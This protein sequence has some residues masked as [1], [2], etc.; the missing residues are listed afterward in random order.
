MQL[1]TFKIFS[2]HETKISIYLRSLNEYRINFLINNMKLKLLYLL[3]LVQVVSYGQQQWRPLGPN[4]FNQ[5]SNDNT[6]SFSVALDGNDIP[7]MAFTSIASGVFKVSVRKF[8]NGYWEYVGAPRFSDNVFLQKVSLAIDNNNVPYVAYRTF[9]GQSRIQKF[10][11]GVWTNISFSE[12]FALP[13]LVFDT[14]NNLNILAIFGASEHAGLRKF[15]G[16]TWTSV[17]PTSISN[18]FTDNLSVDFDSNNIPYVAYSNFASNQTLT[19]KKLNNGAWQNVGD[20]VL[21]TND[22]EDITIRLNDDNVPYVVY[23]NVNF[24]NPV[25]ILK[26]FN[27]TQW[28]AVGP[29]N[30][31]IASNVRNVSFEIDQNDDLVVATSSESTGNTTV[32]KFDGTDWNMFGQ[33]WLHGYRNALVLNSINEPMVSFMDNLAGMKRFDGTQ[34]IILGDESLSGNSKSELFSMTI[35]GDD[36]PYF[37]YHTKD[38]TDIV[39]KKWN[40]VL[41]ENLSDETLTATQSVP[42]TMTTDANNIPYVLYRNWNTEKLSVKKLIANNWVSVGEETFTTVQDGTADAQ[43]VIDNS[44]VLYVAIKSVYNSVTKLKFYK[45]TGANWVLMNFQQLI[46]NSSDLGFTI[47][48][49]NRPVVVYTDANIAGKLQVRK[50]DSTG[51]Q[52]DL[53]GDGIQLTANPAYSY[54]AVDSQNVPYISYAGFASSMQVG[55]YRFFAG[56]WESVGTNLPSQ[57]IELPR[58]LIDKTD[59]PHI[60]YHDRDADNSGKMT[61]RKLEGS[62]WNVVGTAKLSASMASQIAMP[63]LGFTSNNVPVM[64]YS[65]L[66]YFAKFFGEENAL[67]VAQN[68]LAQNKLRLYPNPVSSL[69]HATSDSIIDNIR[70]YDLTG[71]QMNLIRVDDKTL[72]VS[73]LQNGIYI[74]EV[75]TNDATFTSKFVKK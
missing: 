40:G 13:K 7:Y 1:D 72:D 28:V 26:T 42:L 29:S 2:K 36:T 16:S 24:F 45:N 70:I 46:H 44:G 10:I 58:V 31:V 35:A 62:N 63:Y 56:S 32:R 41:W 21:S 54:I 17:G 75:Q 19:V 9:A 61:V 23:K 4:D 25:T 74:I 51:L 47:G 50:L 60:V 66:G 67:S 57:F 15:N 38:D 30:G 53:V 39:V 55:V 64:G 71:K 34:W 5:I 11:N 73:A 68:P 59:V 3:I 12:S 37:A 8:V 33:P 69:L 52:W 49:D 14:Q 6:E 22:A 65:C 43:L 20:I 27:G 48:N 18:G